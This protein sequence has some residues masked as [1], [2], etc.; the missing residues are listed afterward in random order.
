MLIRKSELQSLIPYLIMI[1]IISRCVEINIFLI[2]HYIHFQHY[3]HRT[4]YAITNATFQHIQSM[5][6]LATCVESAV[7]SILLP[8]SSRRCNEKQEIGGIGVLILRPLR[9]GMRCRIPNS[10]QE[11]S[12]S[13][14]HKLTVI[15]LLFGYL[16]HIQ[17]GR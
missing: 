8:W 17:L 5:R 9:P 11:R 2:K 13:T 16:N 1:I 3:K 4:C 14:R 7:T 10:L 6:Y 15:H 12:F